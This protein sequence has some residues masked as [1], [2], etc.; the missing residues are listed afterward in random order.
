MLK[1]ILCVILL[2]HMCIAGGD[3]CIFTS[4]MCYFWCGGVCTDYKW[5]HKY[6]LRLISF[7]RAQ[8]IRLIAGTFYLF[9]EIVEFNTSDIF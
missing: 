9:K 6:I 1:S 3:S 5:A 8:S 4:L 2:M 7:R